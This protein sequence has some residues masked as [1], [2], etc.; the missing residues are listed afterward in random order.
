MHS[1]IA[2]EVQIWRRSMTQHPYVVQM[3]VLEPCF[4][5]ADLRIDI[6]NLLPALLAIAGLAHA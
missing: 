5:P 6:L 4:G 1:C 3:N 2:S